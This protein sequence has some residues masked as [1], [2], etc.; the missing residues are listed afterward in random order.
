MQ[1][2]KVF[3]VFVKSILTKYLNANTN[4]SYFKILKYKYKYSKIISRVYSYVYRG[5]YPT[6][7]YPCRNM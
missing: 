6:P 5:E 1:I 3:E 4:T 7:L 2:M